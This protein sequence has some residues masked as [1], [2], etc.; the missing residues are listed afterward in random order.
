ME[1]FNMLIQRKIPVSLN[2]CRMKIKAA[3]LISSLIV[4]FLVPGLA[5]TQTM[6]S[7]PAGSVIIDMG[8]VP[9]TVANA[10]K[11]Y[12]LVYHLTMEHGIPVK[13]II[14]PGKLK[15]AI[16]FN[17]NGHDFKGGPFI[18]PGQYRT[19][20]VDDE[21]AK[22][23]WAGVIKYTTTSPISV[24]VY[25]TLTV[26]NAPRW[27]LDKQNG[28]LAVPYF[29]NAG[30]P[31][32]AYGG[33]TSTTWKTPA[34]LTCCDDIFVMPHADP[35]WAT[36]GYLMNWN[37]TCKGA[38]WLGCHAGSALEDMFNP[39]IPGQQTNFLSEKNAIASGSGPYFQNALVL[40]TNH[41]AGT[42]PYTYDNGGDPVMQFLGAIDGA[43][44]NGSEQIYLPASAG[45][46]PTT[47]VGGYDPDHPQR[48]LGSNDYKYRAAVIAYGRGYG[49][50]ER[51]MVMLE[52]SHQL[53]KSSTGPESIAAQ[54]AFFNFSLLAAKTTAPDPGFNVILGTLTSGEVAPMSFTVSPPRSIGEFNIQW[55]S[56]CGGTFDDNTAQF[57]NFSVP[58]VSGPTNCVITIVLTEKSIC[59]RAYKSSTSVPVACGL[60]VTT[61]VK[62]A[63]FGLSNGSI[64]LSVVGGPE[65]YQWS[66]ISGSSSGSGSGNLIP[67]LAPGNYTITVITDDGNGCT[68]TF[69]V[70]VN[71]NPQ[72][73][74][75]ASSTN[76]LC[77]NGASGSINITPSGGAPGYTY[78]WTGGATTQNRTGLAA[79]T[80]QVTVTD[81]KGCTAT[82]SA[83]LTQPDAIVI[84]PAITDAACTGGSTGGITLGVTGGIGSYT[85]AWADGPSTANRTSLPAG[86]YSVTVTDAN[87]CTKTSSGISVGEPA[88][89]LSLSATQVNVLCN[90]NSTGSINITASGGTGTVTF[91]WGGGITTEDRLN[92]AAGTYT[93]TATDANGCTA[94][95]STVITQ[96]AAL[97][98]STVLTHVGCPP[99]VAPDGAIALTAGGGTSP[100]TYSIDGGAYGSTSTFTGLTAGSHTVYVKDA[101]GCITSSTVILNTLNSSPT[102]PST[103][104]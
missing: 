28:T 50:P 18:I 98:L 77:N 83:T 90:G 75:S 5:R 44:Q 64:G 31:S 62:P 101:S 38:V 9:Q 80:Y 41:S 63:C 35:V 61:T 20:D 57:V 32:S 70:T 67:G 3:S 13:W 30:I 1:R 84:T 16:D 45:W 46:R 36:H 4:L 66:W 17:Y 22:L 21:I 26:S 99:P 15:D 91:N 96:P 78:L 72:F 53:T 27:T 48:Y 56:S 93:V 34:Q 29:T 76:L 8:V 81:S 58:Q 60:Q 6:E 82:A 103:I 92:L 68:K 97:T 52:A 24:P 88:S 102:P 2:G 39:A 54:R 42:P 43:T 10:L 79:G 87:G 65:P 71:E 11:P 100:Y 69:N 95:L 23:E 25:K 47:V 14:D 51:G 85:Y 37:L 104:K 59:A 89:A 7:F 94:V 12:G 33:P 74:A 19:P 40:W 55:S 86:S 73:T 49:D